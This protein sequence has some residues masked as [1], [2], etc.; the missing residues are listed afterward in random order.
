M[1]LHEKRL[2]LAPID[3]RGVLADASVGLLLV[4]LMGLLLAKR[5]LLGR[6]LALMLL[7]TFVLLSFAMYEFVSVFDSLY[8]LS[9][10]GF[11]GDPTFLGGSVLHARRPLLLALVTA[12]AVLGAAWARPPVSLWWRWWGLGFAVSVFGQV[13]IPTSYAHEEWRERHAIQANLGF[14][15][16]SA[17][18]HRVAISAEVR[19]VFDGDL[20]GERWVGPL[21][22][23]PNVLL[24][25]IEAASGAHL[26]SVAAAE[27]VRSD[28]EMPKL[29]A[30]ARRHV[31]FTHVVSHQRQTNRG[32]YG[33]LC[34]DYP[35][36]LTDQSKMSE[37]VYA[38][39]RRCLPEALRE[40]GYAT[41]YIQSAPLGFMLKDQFMKKAGFEELIGDPF[42]LQS[43]ARTDWGVDDKAFFEQ[44]LG[45]VLRLH[46]AERPF[47]ATLLTVGTHH[48]F[49][50][51]DA[52]P[53][54]GGQTRQARAFRWADD[55]LADFLDELG[56]RGVL[57]DTV[58]IV[59]SDEST[60][61]RQAGSATHRLLSQSWSFAVVMFPAPIVKRVDTVYA[62][63]D[64]ALSVTDLLGFGREAHG[65]Q[66]RSW[67]R[68]YA[69]PRPVFSGNTYA[70]RV[71]MFEP[72]GSAV[73][74]SES[75][76]NCSRSVPLGGLPFGPNRQ[77]E[78][79][80][81]R[82]R[83]LLTEVARLSR[84]GRADMTRA[85]GLDLLVE[86]RV[87]V[88]AADGKRLLIGGQYLRV[89]RGTT[90]RV[91]L[92]LDVLG[93]Q[94]AVELHQD[95][96][97]GG[98]LQLEREDR[99]LRAGE[100]WRLSYEIGVPRDSGQLVVQLYATTVSGDVATIR[101]HDARLTMTA[102][103]ATS[104]AVLVIEDAVSRSVPR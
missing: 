11:L 33:I 76:Q 7:V 62:H 93:E 91:D 51:P 6:F 54:D 104:D 99:E 21:S 5:H 18:P 1:L 63:V 44:S 60:G 74:C 45:P 71:L 75:F 22:K 30:L 67:F 20:G 52:A 29:D 16:P 8:A 98:R 41:S 2:A 72:S 10:A 23:R 79:A 53:A 57:N 4:G 46:A 36:L 100:R 59:T 26:P 15:P 81:E 97:L 24:I 49:T 43:Y 86:E 94:S 96:F 102:G 25:L 103:N 101:F 32:E 64:T 89:P 48:P 3:L 56:R 80:P 14:F 47:F 42:F 19:E 78:P 35:K 28:I 88:R 84:S 65:F 83:Q 87:T 55:A 73:I 40:Q 66:G 70:R 50:F 61:V 12:L 69:S 27:G 31:L 77:S 34:G 13:L 68:D 82:A 37:Q 58:V 39:A 85:E 92:D 17:R 9:H 95:V 38:A 90:L